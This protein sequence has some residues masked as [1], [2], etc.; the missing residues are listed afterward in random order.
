[1]ALRDAGQHLRPF[2]HDKSH[3]LGRKNTKAK[4]EIAAAAAELEEKLAATARK[5]QS[6]KARRSALRQRFRAARD[7]GAAEQARLREEVAANG[8]VLKA[9]TARVAELGRAAGR[10]ASLYVELRSVG[11][12]GGG[13][14]PLF[15]SP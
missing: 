1:M 3:G 6:E 4:N 8:V 5:V 12:A 2:G 11:A 10:L 14:A 13:P 7:G 15:P 9:E